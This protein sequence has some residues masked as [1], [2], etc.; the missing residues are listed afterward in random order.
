VKVTYL[1]DNGS[2]VNTASVLLLI[3]SIPFALAPFLQD[4]LD[5]I[6]N[7]RYMKKDNEKIRE[8][9]INNLKNQKDR[10]TAISKINKLDNRIDAHTNKIIKDVTTQ[11]GFI[12]AKM[13]IKEQNN[14]TGNTNE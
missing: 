3:P 9:A 1:K 5:N 12:G 14:K 7:Y 11:G 2:L 6:Q 4:T 10:A 13:F 8:E